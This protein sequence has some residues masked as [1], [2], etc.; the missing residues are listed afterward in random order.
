MAP[1]V[2]IHSG[3]LGGFI[4][5]RRSLLRAHRVDGHGASDTRADEQ[6]SRCWEKPNAWVTASAVFPP[7][8]AFL[9]LFPP[10]KLL[11]LFWS[12]VLC[13]CLRST[14]RG[15]TLWRLREPPI[16]EMLLILTLVA[17]VIYCAINSDLVDSSVNWVMGLFSV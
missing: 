15:H 17:A 13:V 2:F 9:P 4:T 6:G 12:A 14:T 10:T 1:G 7:G 16:R 8:Q 3:M 11:N 5:R